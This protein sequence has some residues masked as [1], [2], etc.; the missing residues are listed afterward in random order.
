MLSAGGAFGSIEIVLRNRLTDKKMFATADLYG[1]GIGG[2]VAKAGANLKKQV[3]NAVKNNLMQAASDFLGRG[4]V[5]F[6]S[7]NKMGFDDFEGQFIRIGK[8][9]AAL[10]IKAVYSYATFPFISHDPKLLVIQKKITVGWPDL[11][12]WVVSGKLRLRGPNPG[13]W[14]EY[15]RSGQVQGSYDQ[16]WQETLLLTYATGKSTL[17]PSEKSRLTDFVATWA[18]RFP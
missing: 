18:R 17:H 1:G 11:E 4:E 5:F 12:G 10:G 15:D 2:G 8:A 6:T 9:L 3:A 13:D 14:W 7:K 16:S